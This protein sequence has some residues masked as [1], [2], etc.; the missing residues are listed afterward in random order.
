MA[1]ILEIP[2]TPKFGAYRF[3]LTIETRPYLF[4]MRWN[5][6]AAAWYMNVREVDLKPIILGAKIVLGTYIGRRSTH[7]LF[8]RGVLVAV[9]TEQRGREATYD[10]FGTGVVLRWI[11]MPELIIRLGSS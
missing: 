8:N 7:R 4:E 10:S 11:P 5:T 3:G 2:V 6:R 1:D 9:D